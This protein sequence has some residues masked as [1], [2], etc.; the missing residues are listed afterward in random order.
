MTALE[1]GEEVAQ[2]RRRQVQA[3]GDGGRRPGGDAG[4][5]RQRGAD[6]LKVEP[7]TDLTIESWWE[8]A[9]T[10]EDE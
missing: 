3:G 8:Q 9:R 6:E 1:A 10:L 2:N 5:P 7:P 4:R